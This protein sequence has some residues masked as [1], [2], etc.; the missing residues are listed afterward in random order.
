MT[1]KQEELVKEQLSKVQ[2]AD[3]SNYDRENN[4]YHIPHTNQIKLKVNHSYLIKIK[5]SIINNDILKINY[6]EGK[7]PDIGSYII[8]IISILNKIIKVN[9]VKYD[10]E[11]EKETNVWWS[12]YISLNDIEIIKEC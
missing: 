6:N 10:E 5:E 8:D 2:F 12:G 7:V 4:I 9:A 1:N 3:L 11:E